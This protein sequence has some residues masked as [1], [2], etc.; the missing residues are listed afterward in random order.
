MWATFYS[1]SAHTQGTASL[2][3]GAE[4][5]RPTFKPSSEIGRAGAGAPPP[6][7]NTREVTTPP[8]Q[9]RI[10]VATYRQLAACESEPEQ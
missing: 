3:E 10:M 4:R 6:A 2:P 9:F 7:T 8:I 1:L 5:D